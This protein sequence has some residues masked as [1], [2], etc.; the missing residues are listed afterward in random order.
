MQARPQNRVK[1]G[2]SCEIRCQFIIL[3]EIREIRCRF[4]ILSVKS[5][6]E[7]R[8][9]FIILSG[10]NPVSEIRCQFIILSVKSGVKREIRCQA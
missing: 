9:Q 6:V 5:G 3:S 8:C 10:R 4:I 2:V 1:S 7:I